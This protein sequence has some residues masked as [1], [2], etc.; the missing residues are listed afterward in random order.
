[1]LQARKRGATKGSE[2]SEPDRLDEFVV[3]L[4]AL[5]ARREALVQ[6]LAQL[7]H[8]RSSARRSAEEQ[9]EI[10]HIQREIQQIDDGIANLK[11]RLESRRLE[12]P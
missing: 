2:V 3:A 6:R 7:T 4:D 5:H 12:P 10:E 11:Q 8:D 9:A 1:M